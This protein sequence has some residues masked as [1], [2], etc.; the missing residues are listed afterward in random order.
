MNK[1]RKITI[2]QNTD[3]PWSGDINIR[4]SPEIETPFTLFL[5]TPGWCKKTEVRVNGKIITQPV[6]PASYL[7]ISRSWKKGDEVQL[8]LFLRAELLETHPRSSNNGRLAISRG[9]LIYCV[10]TTDNKAC[11]V[12]D[13]LISLNTDF[14]FDFEPQLLGGIGVLRG[15]GLKD[16]SDWKGK[17]YRTYRKERRAKVEPVDIV[18]IPYF[19]WAN[20]EPG[21]R[22]VWIQ[23]SHI[24]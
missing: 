18:A 11:D 22:L 4:V 12:L 14:A 19:A 21:K 17:L 15:K 3:Y 24:D 5:R 7:P 13:I 20:R 1:T 16:K 6:Q 10:E 2:S 9:P 23:R 8:S